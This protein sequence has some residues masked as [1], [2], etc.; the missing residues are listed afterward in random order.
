[1]KRVVFIGIILM[2][3]GVFIAQ[4]VHQAFP[5]RRAFEF[6]Y[7]LKI[8]AIPENATTLDLWIPL[9]Q[10]MRY[11]H[12]SNLK[13][14]SL[15]PYEI[16]EDRVFKNKMAYFHLKGNIP[17]TVAV[18]VQFQ[19][20]RQAAEVLDHPVQVAKLSAEERQE[21]LAPDSLV[22]INERIF[23]EIRKSGGMGLPPLQRAKAF[24]DYLLGTMRYDKSGQGWGRGDALYACDVRKGNCTD[25]HSLFISMARASGIPTRF[26]IGFPLHRNQTEGEIPGYHCWAEFY[27]EGKG[28][29]P[30]DISEA[31]KRPAEKKLLFGG[32]DPDRVAFT[33]GRDI[34]LEPPVTHK[35]L[36]YFIYPF[37]L[38]DGKEYR[39]VHTT[40]R[41]KN[42]SVE[43]K[44]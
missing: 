20:L 11:Q 42:I 23:E 35:R 21:F 3:V 6:T 34:Q 5:P 24:Y 2:Y 27:V 44:S 9:P 13:I 28:W 31:Y 7:S 18:T 8:E 4:T 26:I 40:F 17:A 41:Y 36:N 32:L 1:M 39:Q 38:V 12:I 30:V 16:K 15:V 25:F 33:I 14:R 22:P 19:V 10:D 37:V 43:D 29:I